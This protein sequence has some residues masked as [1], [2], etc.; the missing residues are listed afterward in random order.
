MSLIK[1]K[2]SLEDFFP[3]MAWFIGYCLIRGFFLL[4]LFDVFPTNSTLKITIFNYG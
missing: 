3:N 1:K 2:D 4:N